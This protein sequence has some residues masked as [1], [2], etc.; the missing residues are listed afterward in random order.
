VLTVSSSLGASTSLTVNGNVHPLRLQHLQRGHHPRRGHRQPGRGRNRRHVRPAGPIGSGQSGLDRLL[1]RHAAILGRESKTIIPADSAPAANQAYS[2]DTNGQTVTWATPLTSSGGRFNKRSAAA[3]SSSPPA[4]PISGPTRSP[5]RHAATGRRH[6]QTTARSPATSATTAAWSSPI[7]TR[8]VFGGNDWGSGALNK[9]AAG[10]TH[11]QRQRQHRRQ[12]PG[13][14]GSLALTGPTAPPACRPT[15]PL[16]DLRQRPIPTPAFL[17][18]ATAEPITASPHHRAGLPSSNNGATLNITGAMGDNF[19]VGRDFG[20]RHRRPDGGLFNY[21]LPT[22]EHSR[23]RQQQ[24]GHQRLLQYERRHARF[25][26][27]DFEH[28]L[29]TTVM[30]PPAPSNQSGGLV[31]GVAL[32]LMS[33]HQR[34]GYYNLSGG[35]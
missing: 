25:E 20:Q 15:A 6:E 33:R 30:R 9:Q 27:Q 3:C 22:M 28:R 14:G 12:H 24:C 11:P 34:Q 26:R 7:P 32:P 23:C 18:L 17:W 19:V 5:A 8:R 29:G 4:A 1:R 31:T 2:V 10:Q 21:A 35:Q 13:H 16:H